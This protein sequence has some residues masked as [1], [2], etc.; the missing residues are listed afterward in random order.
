MCAF[1]FSTS[2]LEIWPH[3][4]PVSALPKSHPG[5]PVVSYLGVTER[6]VEVE[7]VSRGFTAKGRDSRE[8]GMLALA[9][10]QA[11][12]SASRCQLCGHPLRAQPSSQS[13]PAF[14]SLS[15]CDFSSW[16]VDHS[17]L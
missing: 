17:I 2:V 8:P 9:V 13:W 1:P 14:L 16:L 7:F 4:A 3:R 10:R 5:G 6:R 12:L 11:G 15:L